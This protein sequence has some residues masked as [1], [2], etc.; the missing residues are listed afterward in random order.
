MIGR[1]E[2]HDLE[3]RFELLNEE[4]R[5]MMAIEGMTLLPTY[6]ASATH[7]NTVHD[8]LTLF[9]T[10]VES[11]IVVND[12]KCE[13]KGSCLSMFGV[14]MII[15]SL[16][17]HFLFNCATLSSDA[18][19][20]SCPPWLQPGCTSSSLPLSS[21]LSFKVLTLLPLFLLSLWC[22]VAENSGP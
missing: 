22:R 9:H 11:Q 19:T 13:C 5:D 17:D 6:T 7:Q 18:A 10:E 2:E 21:F 14:Y 16:H 8:R 15:T 20:S 1:L 3:R 12:S 4:L